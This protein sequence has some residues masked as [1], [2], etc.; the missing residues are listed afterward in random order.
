MVED[1]SVGC[2][3]DHS[4]DVNNADSSAPVT[5]L[6]KNQQKKQRRQEAARQKHLA[7]KAE[8]KAARKASQ[9]KKLAEREQHIAQMTE[10]ERQ[11]WDQQTQGKRQA[12]KQAEKDRKEK[13]QRAL[14]SGQRIIIDLDFADKMTGAELRSVCKQ[15]AYSYSANTRA[16]R[17][18]HLILTSYQANL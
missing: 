8:E 12:R 4:L 5:Q 2:Q 14:D 3:A 17:P 13:L 10:K 7:K 9:E 1:E 6:S 18:G 15:L 16:A 11:A